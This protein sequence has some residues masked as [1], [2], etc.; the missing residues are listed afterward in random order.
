MHQPPVYA[1]AEG[2]TTF[3]VPVLAGYEVRL[4][5]LSQFMEAMEGQEIAYTIL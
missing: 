3:I 5:L 4:C 1:L 2:W